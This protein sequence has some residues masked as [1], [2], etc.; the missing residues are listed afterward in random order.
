MREGDDIERVRRKDRSVRRVKIFIDTMNFFIAL[1]VIAMSIV[2]LS[3]F[4]L[5]KRLYIIIFLSALVMFVLNALRFIFDNKFL[6]VLFFT[7][8]AL[9]AFIATHS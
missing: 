7:L 9:M 1:A 6:A 5:G 2:V 8:A 4:S 3:G